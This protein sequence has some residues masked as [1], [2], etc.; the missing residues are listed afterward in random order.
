MEVNTKKLA[1]LL[2]VLKVNLGSKVDIPLDEFLD[3]K[4]RIINIGIDG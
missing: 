3:K 2:S 1:K 4:V